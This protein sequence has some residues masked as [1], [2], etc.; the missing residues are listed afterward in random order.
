MK[1]LEK[2]QKTNTKQQLSQDSTTL[3]TEEISL[4]FTKAVQFQQSGQL[5]EAEA[6]YKKI[7][8][9]NQDIA[10]VHCNLGSVQETLEDS[11]KSYERALSIKPDYADAYINK[12][13][14]LTD[15]GRLDE[16]IISYKIALEIHPQY[17]EAKCNLG[18]ALL[19]IRQTQGYELIT[20]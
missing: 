12:G 9:F 17:A 19:S 2:I 20:F 11:L 8:S 14:I 1:G 15:L 16:A 3:T 4:L 18:V 7:L 5:K 13:N 10:E 6:L